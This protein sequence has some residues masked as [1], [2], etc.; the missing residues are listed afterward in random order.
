MQ[1]I[2]RALRRLG[3]P[4]IGQIHGYAVGGGCELALMCDLR[5]AARG[6]PLRVHRGA[7]GCHHNPGRHLQSGQGGGHGA[8]P[9]R[10]ST[11]RT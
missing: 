2:G 9:S 11:P 3:K 6:D 7:G 8:G 5:L 1:D 10:C 4:V